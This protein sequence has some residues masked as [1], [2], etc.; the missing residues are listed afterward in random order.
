MPASR[1]RLRAHFKQ[2]G[3]FAY[4]TES[5]YGLGCDPHNPHALRTLLRLKK[6][7]AHKGLIVV[8]ADLAQLLPLLAPLDIQQQQAL[9]QRWQQEEALSILLPAAHHLHPLLRGK[10]Q[11]IA[12]R[13]SKHPAVQTLCQRLG[14]AIVSTSANFAKQKSAKTARTCQ[15]QFGK[16]VWVLQ[17][18]IGTRKTP[19]KIIDGETGKILR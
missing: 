7:P 13:I 9:I 8:A 10:H 14:Q 6:R 2:G 15:R 19:S 3:L 11:K 17:G 12:V 5:C 1:S 4:P 18:Q 16:K